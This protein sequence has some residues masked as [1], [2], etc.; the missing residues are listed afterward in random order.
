M[1]IFISKH[2]PFLIYDPG[3]LP[4]RLPSSDYNGWLMKEDTQFHFLPLQ[5]EDLKAQLETCHQQLA[6]SNQHKQELENQLKAAVDR[7]HQIRAGY[8]S[9]VRSNSFSV[10]A[11]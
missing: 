2:K 11:F 5:V 3:K 8:I 9:P 6:D 4:A 1:R 10:Y 7:E